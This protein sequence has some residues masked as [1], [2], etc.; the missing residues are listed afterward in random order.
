MTSMPTAKGLEATALVGLVSGTNL[1]IRPQLGLTGHN[2]LGVKHL[3]LQPLGLVG[4]VLLPLDGNG[5]DSK[6]VKT[7]K[8]L[9]GGSQDEMLDLRSPFVWF[10]QIHWHELAPLVVLLLQL[11]AAPLAL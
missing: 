3:V 4:I 8:S 7:G 11:S 10:K 6:M 9:R 5:L 2:A 1:M